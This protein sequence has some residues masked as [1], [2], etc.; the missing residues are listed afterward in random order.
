MDP[1]GEHPLWY[2]LDGQ[3]ITIHEAERLLS[4]GE[5]RRVALTHLEGWE[6]STVF[7]VLDHS[8]GMPLPDGTREP[9]VLWETMAWAGERFDAD[10]DDVVGPIRYSSRDSALAGH[11]QVVADI[12]ASLAE[13]AR[14][15]G[16]HVSADEEP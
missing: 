5:A 10:R 12:K 3:P 7:L 2:G 4:D 8:L 15:T 1:F 14:L 16:E 6:I 11:D 13:I 9:P